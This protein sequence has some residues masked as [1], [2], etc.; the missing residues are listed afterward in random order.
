MKNRFIL[1]FVIAP[2][3]GLALGG[4]KIYHSLALKK[5]E[6]A[7]TTFQI[8]AGEPFSKINYRL[9]EA[10][11][12]NST[13]I[14]H[15][16]CQ[17]QNLLTSFKTGIYEIPTGITMLGVIELF[18]SGKGML[19][20]VTIPEGKNLYEIA[21]ILEASKITSAQDFIK[22]AK[23]P[24]FV[25]SLD[26]P[27]DTLEGYLYPETYSFAPQTQAR[28][29]AT[30]MVRVFRSKTAEL[31]FSLSPLS[32]K[33]VVI[34]ASM[35]EKETGAGWER[36]IIA[37]VFMNRLNKR[38]RL[39]S[40]PTTIYGM[41]ERYNGNL[42]RS[43]LL[44]TTDYNTYKIPALP[45]GPIANPGIAAI[46]AVL[47]PAKHK[48]IFFVSKNDG[49]HVFTETLKEHNQ[50]VDE[51]QRNRANRQGRSWRDLNQATN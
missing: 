50:A 28:E 45:K 40:D 19:T 26:L 12:I 7:P 38:M 3:F 5:Y 2:L 39:Q 46:Q 9:G 37:G 23:D 35:V 10:G 27:G 33:D 4:L 20:S 24:E 36:P 25:R 31:D 42:K 8:H 18:Q 41:W 48:Y 30:A 32:P 17:S 1:F 16:Y 13:K 14:F 43:D 51:W 11:I 34:L 22:V 6:G 44:E 47:T 21:A 15:R 29:V 49:T